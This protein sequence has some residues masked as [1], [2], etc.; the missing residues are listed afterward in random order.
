MALADFYLIETD[1]HILSIIIPALG[2]VLEVPL[3]MAVCQKLLEIDLYT[4]SVRQLY[5][6]YHI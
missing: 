4:F 1:S 5:T 2:R 6:I 3:L